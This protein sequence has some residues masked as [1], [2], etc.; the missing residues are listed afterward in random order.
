MSEARRFNFLLLWGN[1]RRVLRLHVPRWITAA[2]LVLAALPVFTLGAIH[3][4][5]VALRRQIP[6]VQAL[7]HQVREQQALI[8]TFQRRV[9]EVRAEVAAWRDLHARIWE[10]LGPEAGP[11]RK[12]TGIGGGEPLGPAASD[13]DALTHELDLLAATVSEEGQ[14]LRALERLMTKAGRVIARSGQPRR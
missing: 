3:G 8:D 10:P 7:R 5:H 13:R 11:A 9:A 2:A 6:Q 12:G 1:G 14:N 4:D